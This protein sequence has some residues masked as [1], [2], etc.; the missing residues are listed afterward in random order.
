MTS[1]RPCDADIGMQAGLE[2][3]HLL[4]VF[5]GHIETFLSWFVDFSSAIRGH[6]A[7][8][9][10]SHDAPSA[11]SMTKADCHCA[12]SVTALRFLP[13]PNPFKQSV[14][15]STCRCRAVNMCKKQTFC[16]GQA[17]T[18]IMAAA[19]QAP[20]PCAATACL[21]AHFKVGIHVNSCPPY[22]LQW[23]NMLPSPQPHSSVVLASCATCRLLPADSSWYS[24]EC[25]TSAHKHGWPSP[26]EGPIRMEHQNAFR[27]LKSVVTHLWRELASHISVGLNIF[28]VD[29]HSSY[30]ICPRL[31]L[32]P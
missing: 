15:C 22:A 20:P 8:P 13:N 26:P 9:K 4:Y 11:C 28:D 18:R 32:Q 10:S 25:C 30:V 14:L 19:H 7:P 23:R 12:P 24:L 17:P 21:P 6:L 29:D 3:Y 27:P 5:R 16:S 31:V 1:Y 2:S